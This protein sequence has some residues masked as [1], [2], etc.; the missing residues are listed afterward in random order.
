MLAMSALNAPTLSSLTCSLRSSSTTTLASPALNRVLRE[1]VQDE[2]G[3]R[4]LARL[5]AVLETEDLLVRIQV[6]ASQG[7][8]GSSDLRWEGRPDLLPRGQARSEITRSQSCP[9]PVRG[10]SSS[11]CTPWSSLWPS[12]A[13]Y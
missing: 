4:P 13:S 11:S 3:L 6:N 9:V 8:D 5:K 12:P 7:F 2:F 10:S 1:E